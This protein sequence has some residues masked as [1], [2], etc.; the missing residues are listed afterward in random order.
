MS[1]KYLNM[2]SQI[3]CLLSFALVFC[4]CGE[5]E[6]PSQKSTDSTTSSVSQRNIDIP[7]PFDTTEYKKY[8]DS[9]KYK[10]LAANRFYFQVNIANTQS[11]HI[12]VSDLTNMCNN[13]NNTIYLYDALNDADDDVF[14]MTA[15][16]SADPSDEPTCLLYY[17]WVKCP[18]FCDIQEGQSISFLDAQKFVRKLLAITKPTAEPNRIKIDIPMCNYIQGSN[19]E[20][21]K[22]SASY[23]DGIIRATALDFPSSPGV[24]VILAPAPPPARPHAPFVNVPVR[25]G[26]VPIDEPLAGNHVRSRL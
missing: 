7:G 9:F 20:Y 12:K 15:E 5:G 14:I 21:F 17:R 13:C 22:I 19:E 6:S 24:P 26:S 11:Y 23:D 8:I 10:T 4:S 1:F 2:K 25:P 3:I 18:K 16:N